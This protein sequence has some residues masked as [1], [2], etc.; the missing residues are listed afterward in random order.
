MSKLLPETE[1]EMLKI[2]GVTKANFDKYGKHMLE[3]TQQ[4]AMQKLGN[5]LYFL[6]VF[7]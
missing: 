1:D 3:I 4:C 6:I 7:L 5:F 2:D